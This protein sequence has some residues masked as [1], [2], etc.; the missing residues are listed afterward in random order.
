[1]TEVFEDAAKRVQIEKERK[2]IGDQEKKRE[3]ITEEKRKY[4]KDKEIEQWYILN[5]IIQTTAI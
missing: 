4:Q 1:M 3:N 2:G 5:Y